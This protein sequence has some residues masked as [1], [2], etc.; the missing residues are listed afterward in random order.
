MKHLNKNAQSHHPESLQ[1]LELY[2]TLCINQA[3]I[4]AAL[5]WPF[6][7]GIIPL[8]RHKDISQPNTFVSEKT[9][10]SLTFYCSFEENFTASTCNNPI[11]TSWCLVSTHQTHFGCWRCVSQWCTEIR[12]NKIVPVNCTWGIRCRWQTTLMT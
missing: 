1:S 11:V 9:D 8:I 2:E 4:H 5:S 6:Q 7:L 3:G 12:A 10:E